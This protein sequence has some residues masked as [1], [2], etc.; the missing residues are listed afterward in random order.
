MNGSV[1]LQ[2]LTA[3]RF[4]EGNEIEI[5]KI[6]IS[7]LYSSLLMGVILSIIGFYLSDWVIQLISDDPNIISKASSYLAYRF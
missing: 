2:I 6:G 5:G 3:R 4:G 7:V 1:G